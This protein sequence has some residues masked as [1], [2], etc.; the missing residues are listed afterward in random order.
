MHKYQLK[1]NI[2]G[3]T[4]RS[5]MAITNLRNICKMKFNDEYELMIID[6]LDNPD[7][8]EQDKIMATPTLIKVLPPPIRKIIG[9]LSDT[10]KVL[11]GLDLKNI[12]E[13]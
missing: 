8:A 4:S 2:T 6:V 12:N 10:Q 13:D 5:E 7:L 3:K 1:L 11:L 9:D